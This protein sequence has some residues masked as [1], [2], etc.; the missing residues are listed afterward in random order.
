MKAKN[1]T[2]VAD[3]TFVLNHLNV[4]NMARSWLP[5]IELAGGIPGTTASPYKYLKSQTCNSFFLSSQTSAA[6]ME[7]EISNLNAFRK[8]Y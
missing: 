7:F 6:E 2:T 4:K 8:K 3:A 1:T 5:R